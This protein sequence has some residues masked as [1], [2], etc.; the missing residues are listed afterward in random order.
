VEAPRRQ[1]RDEHVLCTSSHG[2]ASVGAAARNAPE[3]FPGLTTNELA[4]LRRLSAHPDFASHTFSESSH[5]GAEVIDESGRSYDFLG[6]PQASAHWNRAD[7]IASIDAHLLKANDFTV[8]DVTGFASED[9]AE[10]RAYVNALPNHV[11][12]SIIRLGF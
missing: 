11:R 6:Q 1:Q 12:A 10:V 5:V 3:F 9:I 4:T 7:F 8:I 2:V